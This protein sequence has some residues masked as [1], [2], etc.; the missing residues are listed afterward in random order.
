M[1][2]NDAGRVNFLAFL[3]LRKNLMGGVFLALVAS[4]ILSSWVYVS[5]FFMIFF[6]V[7]FIRIL[8][9][10]IAKERSL[11]CFI[12]G[13]VIIAG[14][15]SVIA[16]V[17]SNIAVPYHAWSAIR[18]AWP[19]GILRGCDFYYKD[20]G[21]LIGRMY[22]PVFPLIYLLSASLNNFFAIVHVGS[23]ISM[24]LYFVPAML[25]FMYCARSRQ[26]APPSPAVYVFV[27]VLITFIS[28]TLRQVAFAVHVDAAALGFGAAA[29]FMLIRQDRPSKKDLFFSS[30]FVA[31]AFWSKQTAIPLVVILPVYALICYGKNV[32][33][34]YVLFIVL[35][36]F[37]LTLMFG[38][39]FGF[40]KLFYNMFFIPSRQPSALGGDWFSGMVLATP[41]LINAIWIQISLAV[42]LFATYFS[43][44][45]NRGQELLLYWM[46]EKTWG[47][48]FV[49]GIAMVPVSLLGQMK[50]GGDVNT[51]SPSPFYWSIA[52]TI[53][54]VDLFHASLRQSAGLKRRG[55]L[56]F[57]VALVVTLNVATLMINQDVKGFLYSSPHSVSNKVMAFINKHAGE[58]YFPCHN[59]EHLLIE[60]KEYHNIDG[61]LDA[62]HSRI[63]IEPSRLY[64]FLPVDMRLIALETDYIFG[65]WRHLVPYFPAFDRQI[66]FLEL[67]EFTVFVQEGT[68]YTYFFK[69]GN[70]RDCGHNF[71]FE[72]IKS[73]L[74]LS[75]SLSSKRIK[76]MS[77]HEFLTNRYPEL[78]AVIEPTDHGYIP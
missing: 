52:L 74:A 3:P 62:R 34:S 37:I 23:L 14:V 29:C 5:P 49:I 6:A 40:D 30:L 17:V 46:K 51:L 1:S 16:I 10:G 11:K 41:F 58:V 27:F 48:F 47:L 18:S 59:L 55:L 38:A 19:A 63:W 72:T 76:R 73:N 31:L 43:L 2:N 50:V 70:V 67:P 28:T 44:K 64:A 36:G 65:F 35:V 61:L 53:V 45:Y 78:R 56:F 33:R 13:L 21:H 60:K 26:P 24:F 32:F 39:V 12:D 25:I 9:K 69:L 15:V 66:Y 75:Y 77:K 54:L 71:H 57:A 22:G 68:Y 8:I 7:L 20:S 42:F 4:F